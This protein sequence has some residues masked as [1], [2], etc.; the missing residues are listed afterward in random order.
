MTNWLDEVFAVQKPVIAMLHLSAL[1]GDPGYDSA[2]GIRA[3]VDRAKGELAALRDGG[4]D[5]V[6]ISNEFSLPYLTKTEPITA[7]TMARIIGE[8]LPDL[9]LPYGVN[10]LWDGRASIDLAVATGAQWVREIFTGVYAS[11]FGLW[12]TNVGAVARHRHR[13]GGAGVKLLFN[14]VPESAVYL[15]D[16][17]LASITKTTV[18]ATRPDGICVSGLT[19]G[20]STDSQAL[21]VVKDEAGDVPVFV[22]TGVRAHNAAEQ[23]SIA[24]GAIVGTYFKEDGVFENRAVQSRVTELMTVVREFRAT[25]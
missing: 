16:R 6:M 21:Q 10:V 24:D 18:F 2:A 25:L 12:D 13:I 7:I 9:T 4:V 20:A 14:I 3:V 1:P 5:G 15:S 22:N 8:L 11:D 19:A 23:L 17:D